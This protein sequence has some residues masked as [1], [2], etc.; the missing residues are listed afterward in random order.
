[1]TH[2]NPAPFV[3]ANPQT[4]AVRSQAV[5]WKV[6]I[7]DDEPSVHQIT[8]AIITEYEILG[9]PIECLS[10]YGDAD[11]RVL[12][13][14]HPD[15]AICLLDVVMDTKE[16]GLKLVQ[17]I[18]KDLNNQMMRIVLR[19]G[20]PGY[21]P[22]KEVFIQ[23]DINDYKTKTE[24]TE[25]RLFTTLLG[26]LRDYQSLTQLDRNNRL[27]TDVIDSMPEVYLILNLNGEITGLNS[28]ALALS[29]LSREQGTGKKAWEALPLLNSY[30][31][32]LEQ[33][34]TVGKVCR[35]ERVKTKI[36]QVTQYFDLMLYPLTHQA[37]AALILEEV[38]LKVRY[39]EMVIQSEKMLSV[40]GLAAGIAHEINNPLSAILQ[41]A[42]N[43]LRRLGPEMEKN[44]EVAA[45]YNIDIDA[46]QIYLK[47]RKITE[48]LDHIVDAAGRAAGIVET[49]LR[50][51][52]KSES[53]K[54][55]TN[56]NELVE[57]TLRLITKDYNL[58][59]S[60]VFATTELKTQLDPELPLVPL[61]M[62]EIQQVLINLVKNAVQAFGEKIP[63]GNHPVITVSTQ[64]MAGKVRLE[65][66]DNGPGMPEEIR[67]RILEP[68]FTTKEVGQGTG[69]GLAVSYFIIT[70]NH[71]GS[72]EVL[73][74][75]GKGTRVQVDLPLHLEKE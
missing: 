16:T 11:A 37:G 73:S 74:E 15:A 25:E 70:N 54:S 29:G 50:F 21:A 71:Q 31:T 53:R 58:K 49:M 33:A 23:F 59:H 30:R 68:F 66:A 46:L 38:S 2:T 57:S 43:T 19:T 8:K 51:S 9:R 63:V 6:L 52:R 47:E 40:G 34:L 36:G 65:V 60:E 12:L 45:S 41:G 69:L 48:F 72:L 3:F 13:K 42:Q 44:R 17:Y 75:Q 39:E 61:E 35:V 67:R 18:R 28:K 24:L 1:M 27:L 5:P 22:E 26:A 20:Q 7:I 56:L 4:K 55:S 64:R 62:T 10:A 14:E 32:E